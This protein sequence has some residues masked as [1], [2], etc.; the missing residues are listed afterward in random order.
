M[1]AGDGAP[2]AEEQE[3]VSFF[4]DR[5]GGRAHAMAQ[6]GRE[7]EVG[8]PDQLAAAFG[9]HVAYLLRGEAWSGMAAPSSRSS[10]A[11]SGAAGARSGSQGDSPSVPSDV[12]DR[13]D[14]AEA[15]NRDAGADSR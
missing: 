1:R 4:E 9:R 13:L 6:H 11:G 10:R 5:A 8:E 14:E 2:D 15:V 7:V 3:A 12:L